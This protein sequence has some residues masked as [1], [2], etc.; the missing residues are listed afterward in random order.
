MTLN[1]LT[2]PK[3]KL[4]FES[5]SY[6]HLYLFFSLF[7]TTTKVTYFLARGANKYIGRHKEQLCEL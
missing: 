7:Q 4:H 3:L 6:S 1:P 2:K 5:L